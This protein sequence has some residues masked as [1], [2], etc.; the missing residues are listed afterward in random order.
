MNSHTPDA[1]KHYPHH[2]YMHLYYCLFGFDNSLQLLV[3]PL[4][5]AE[6][7]SLHHHSDINSF[8]LLKIHQ[9]RK[10]L[11]SFWVNKISD[12]EIET[13]QVSIFHIGSVKG[14]L[15][16]KSKPTF[17]LISQKKHYIGQKTIHIVIVLGISW[18][19]A[20]SWLV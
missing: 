10:I 1:C 6:E 15:F 11:S 12:R 5:M 18:E 13:S 3:V 7:H 16:P 2:W 4:C 8:S 20:F 17:Y 19:S 14:T 9:D